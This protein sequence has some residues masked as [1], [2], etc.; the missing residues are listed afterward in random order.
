M[1]KHLILLISCLLAGTV[2]LA[3]PDID[4]QSVRIT[5]KFEAQLAEA[6]K[7][8][9]E[10]TLPNETTTPSPLRYD[11]ALKELVVAYDA[12]RIRPVSMRG[13]KLPEDFKGYFKFGG[14]FPLG[15]FA[16]AGY[17]TYSKNENFRIGVDFDHY[18]ANNNSSVENQKYA[19]TGADIK[20]SYY[21]DQGFA[22]EGD[23]GF[24]RDVYHFYGYNFDGSNETEIP[25]DDV[26]QEFD[27]L[28]FNARIF[29]SEA[30]VADFT[31]SAG[32]SYYLLNDNYGVTE[33]DVDLDLMGTKWLNDQHE[34]TVQILSDFT[35]YS[36]VEKQSLNNFYIRPSFTFHQ[37]NF[38][39]KAG[40]NL[41][42]HD[43]TAFFFPDAS[44]EYNLLDSRLAVF[45][46]AEGNLE[47][48]TFRK[49][50]EY[51][52]YL[53]SR[54]AIGFLENTS[55]NHFF[56]GVK[57]SVSIFDYNAQAGYKDAKNLPLYVPTD[58]DDVRRRYNVVYDTVGIVN[59][60]GSVIANVLSNLQVVG[61]FN[62]NIY[63]P[64]NEE[65]AW[66]L[67]SVT[68]NAAVIHTTLDDKLQL[69]GD[70]F[71]QDGIPFPNELELNRLLDLSI[72]AEYTFSK[73]F[74]GWLRVNNLA[75]NKYERWQYYPTFGINV[76]AG[77]SARF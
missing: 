66:G 9:V 27:L 13:E 24:N 26:R 65:K 17:H 15:L 39:V 12:P 44:A 2:V 46:G 34:L 11:I 14:G 29:N 31:Y 69:R 16:E 1:I 51:N 38:K 8:K 57:G 70:L 55:L 71:L 75:N 48:N 41:A 21:F 50:T 4:D 32:V 67:P 76:L 54:N 52:P 6:E 18:N 30:T 62:T 25:D 77:I 33:Q 7:L 47:K 73:N 53:S 49:L 60:S 61:T 68:V 58:A 36:E 74:G 59:V 45:V 35:G 64:E 43:D 63:D 42:W 28:D 72:G 37:D 22:V 5:K 10:P 40:V 23:L 19:S 20:G 3:Q 56:G